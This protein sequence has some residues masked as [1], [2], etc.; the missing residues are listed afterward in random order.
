M[1]SFEEMH[2][3]E[4]SGQLVSELTTNGQENESMQAEESEENSK[5][6][7]KTSQP[8]VKKF[9]FYFIGNFDE[10]FSPNQ[11]SGLS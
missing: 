7:P 6:M 3:F 10:T 2:R 11:R 9:K 1:H 4:K 5:L 8:N